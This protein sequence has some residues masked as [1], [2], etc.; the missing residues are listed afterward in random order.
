M[1]PMEKQ[2]TKVHNYLEFLS[3]GSIAWETHKESQ[4]ML[5]LPKPHT[6]PFQCHTC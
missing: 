2:Q 1:E 3:I 6:M 4:L 5:K